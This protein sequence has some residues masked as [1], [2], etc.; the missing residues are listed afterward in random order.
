MKSKA[1]A[2]LIASVIASQGSASKAVE[3]LLVNG[4]MLSANRMLKAGIKNPSATISYICKTN[5][6]TITT[7]S[8]KNCPI[9]Y[10]N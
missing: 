4:W 1:S 10:F 3:L 2:K 7:K 8:G 6:Y 9:Y 5:G